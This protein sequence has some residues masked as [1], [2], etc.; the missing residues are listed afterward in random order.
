MSLLLFNVQSVRNKVDELY[1]FLGSCDFPDVLVLNEHFLKTDEPACLQDYRVISCYSRSN[2]KQGGTAILVHEHFL[3][4]F[5]FVNISN[6]D[7]MIVEGEFEFSICM[8]KRL[9]LLIICMYHPPTA[10]KTCF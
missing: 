6:Y 9:N 5:I 1:V 8:C 2:I 10:M 7:N 4:Q 3:R